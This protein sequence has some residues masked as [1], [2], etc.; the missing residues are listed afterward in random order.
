MIPKYRKQFNSEFTETNYLQLNQDLEKAVPGT[1]D[2]RLAETPI[3]VDTAF[4]EKMLS[5]CE[6]IIDEILKPD[7]KEKT[8]PALLPN[9]KICD[10]KEH[11]ECL[12]FDFGICGYTQGNIFLQLIEMQGFPSLFAF[13]IMQD[14]LIRDNFNIPKNCTSYLNNLN[15]QSYI[16][17]FK[18]V[19]INDTPVESV[20]LL[21]LF[22]E[23]QKTRVDF[24]CTTLYFGIEVVCL[25]EIIFDNNQIF[26]MHPKT[27]VKTQILKIYNRIIFDELNTQDTAIQQKAN[28]LFLNASIDCMPHPNWFYRISKYTLPFLNHPYIPET[29]FLKDIKS[30][31]T[32]LENY[33]LKP[34]FS[35]AGQGVIIH[36]KSNDITDIKNPENWILQKKVNYLN[37]IETPDI[38]AKAEIR[39]FYFWEKNA[40]RPIATTNLARL[41]KGDMIGVRYNKDKAWVG[42]ALVYFCD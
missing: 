37:I 9:F 21:E 19:F 26:Y 28:T 10:E 34:L 20:I 36:L 35:F 23:K 32:D 27:K 14:K 6:Y 42:G 15:E 30:I 24:A 17:L 33:V 2:F 8:A 3:F 12:F 1:L 18:K 25:T 16:D 5:A 40:L 39:L 13:Q 38:P 7:F 41:S 22:P 4:K 11:P 29:K 31:P